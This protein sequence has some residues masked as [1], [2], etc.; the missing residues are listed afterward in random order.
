M[1]SPVVDRS[2]GS[3]TAILAAARL[4]HK[5]RSLNSTFRPGSSRNAYGIRVTAFNTDTPPE[6]SAGKEHR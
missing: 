2:V 4:G 3:P 5:Q 6:S 1:P